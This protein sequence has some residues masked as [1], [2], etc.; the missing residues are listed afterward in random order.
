ML[1][2]VEPRSC[3]CCSAG[4]RVEVVEGAGVDFAGLRR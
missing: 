4:N 3:I 2:D 1:I